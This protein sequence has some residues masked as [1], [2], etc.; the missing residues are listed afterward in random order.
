MVDFWKEAITECNV[1]HFSIPRLLNPFLIFHLS[2][3]W[4]QKIQEKLT[5]NFKYIIE[6]KS[7]LVLSLNFPLFFSKLTL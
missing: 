2:V 4:L 1:R 3:V 7:S 5:L 6:I